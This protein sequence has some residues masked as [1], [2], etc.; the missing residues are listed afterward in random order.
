MANASRHSTSAGTS[1]VSVQTGEDYESP[2][3]RRTLL[4][5]PTEVIREILDRTCSHPSV[6]ARES[7]ISGSNDSRSHG[8][9]AT[10][11]SLDQ[12]KGFHE[13]YANQLLILLKTCRTFYHLS[14][15]RLYE[16]PVLLS[17]TAIK[18]FYDTIK[19]SQQGAQ[20]NLTHL[21]KTLVIYPAR[22]SPSTPLMEAWAA[23]LPK[24]FKRLSYLK[25]FA[26][27]IT[28][29]VL[30]LETIAE[31]LPPLSPLENLDNLDV[32]AAFYALNPKF[33]QDGC[34]SLI[35]RA[36]PRL[37][38]I[39]FSTINLIE[40]GCGVRQQSRFITS[41]QARWQRTADSD[42]EEDI[43][44]EY[45]PEDSCAP[46]F[47]QILRAAKV[48]VEWEETQHEGEVET[49]REKGLESLYFFGDTPIGVGVFHE[50]LV[51]LPN[52]RCLH[53]DAFTMLTPSRSDTIPFYTPRTKR[54]H[55]PKLVESFS[56]TNRHLTE[57]TFA[58]MLV[59]STLTYGSMNTL[60]SS[61]PHLTH[62]EIRADFVS[63]EFF[64]PLLGQSKHPLVH[65]AFHILP[66]HAPPAFTS[67]VG[68][69]S[70]GTLATT[71][72][73][74][75]ATGGAASLLDDTVPQ[76]RANKLCK[77]V[78]VTVCPF[79]SK[80]YI[81]A[82]ALA[83]D[84][85]FFSEEYSNVQGGQGG[86]HEGSEKVVSWP[87]SRQEEFGDE[88]EREEKFHEPFWYDLLMR[89]ARMGYD[90]GNQEEKDDHGESEE[91]C[92]EEE[93]V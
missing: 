22:S 31:S 15:P 90:E 83:V 76:A 44:E 53:L 4:D 23:Y 10:N 77:I 92:E 19:T 7:D 65:L 75:A 81:D 17:P 29:S 57:L 84:D 33:A 52:L 86:E 32:F 14:K 72:Q 13:I 45:S 89:L 43:I 37:K 61:L 73:G 42:D 68:T 9:I 26:P 34:L 8:W 74:I 3:P 62:L 87:T 11:A 80:E 54:L 20:D 16:A 55:L 35:S 50:M 12:M 59:S 46:R 58:P 38:R 28:T 85:L 56:L 70:Y 1:T 93:S 41:A 6:S 64:R 49:Q 2:A 36:S 5:L 21:V 27:G 47:L 40:P 66:P 48:G 79:P 71:P 63:P 88:E 78:A 51:N 18:K 60:L 24:F 25:T 30:P 82:L 69:A 91:E 67:S 39:S